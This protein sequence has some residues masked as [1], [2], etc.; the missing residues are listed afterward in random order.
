MRFNIILKISEF[1]S[2]LR[3]LV[4]DY[5]QEIM[6]ILSNN[7]INKKKKFNYLQYFL[8]FCSQSAASSG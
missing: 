1:Y 6:S 4:I 7:K 5:L 2:N 8:P 3:I